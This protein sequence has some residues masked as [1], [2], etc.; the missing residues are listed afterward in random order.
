MGWTPTASGPATR[1][2]SSTSDPG[3]RGIETAGGKQRGP[4]R[5][6]FRKTRQQ[7]GPEPQVVRSNSVPPLL[8]TA[9]PVRRLCVVFGR[10][11]LRVSRIILTQEKFT[12]SMNRLSL[13][14]ALICPGQRPYSI[15]NLTHVLLADSPPRS[16]FAPLLIH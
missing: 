4:Y 3:T 5:S 6:S 13:S 7:H 14:K 11:R 2:R 12:V 9:K 16:S 10:T 8:L 1:A 15:T